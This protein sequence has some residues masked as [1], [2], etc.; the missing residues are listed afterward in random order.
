MK[1]STVIYWIATGLLCLLMLGSAGMYILNHAE[2]AKVFNQLGY[3][4]Y[5]VYSLATAKI[6]GV[7]TIL[8]KFS[9]PLKEW[10][11]A[12]FCYDLLLA[13]AAHYFSGVPS[14]LLAIVGL[15]L[16]IMSYI[17]DKKLYK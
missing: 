10:A 4:A 7:I 8:T 5:L 17:F 6:L 15:V 3:P 11:Y 16:L 2:I 9:K 12:G 13:A 14:P 1:I